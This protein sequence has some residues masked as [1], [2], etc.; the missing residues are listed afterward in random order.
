M[1]PNLNQNRYDHSLLDHLVIWL[2]QMTVM[3]VKEFMQLGNDRALLIF[4][5]YSFTTNILLVGGTKSHDL[6]NANLVVHDADHSAA[7]R[8]LIYRFQQPYFRFT[9]EV[10]DAGEGMR[11]VEQGRA[12]LYL[13]IPE[14]FSRN[15]HRGVQGAE[16][17]LL[18]DTSNA[19]RGYLA[20]SYSANIGAE[21]SRDWVTQNQ[22]AT[23]ETPT[24][25]NRTRIRYNPTLNEAWFNTIAEL[26]IMMT[27]ACLMLPAAA[28]V[29]EKERGTIEQL[30]VS[31]LTPFQIMFSKVLAMM[32]VITAGAAISIFGI[33]GPVFA[34]PMRGSLVL[35]FALTALFAFTTAGLGLVI[36]TFAR[37]AAQVG[38]LVLLIIMPIIVLSGTFTP[39]DS[40]PAALNTIMNV[41][42]LRHFIEIAY[43]ILLR[44]AGIETIW[45]SALAM[46]LLG[47]VLFGWGWRRF[48]R[49][50]H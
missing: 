40:M 19:T 47:C 31:P 26:L 23:A 32:T 7:S 14:D 10:L 15:L 45:D 48:R 36:A 28:L 24:I 42:P 39:R 11:R 21:F 29:R 34:V 49:Q 30:L 46:L 37:N 9:G 20:S 43:G 4:I 13:D 8:D 22:A 3:T 2:R 1:N 50:F 5:L 41:S 16:V 38:M 12:M 33:M 44:G 35:F 25:D 17:Q 6:Q 27:V 18:V